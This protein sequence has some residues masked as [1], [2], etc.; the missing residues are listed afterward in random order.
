MNHSAIYDPVRDRMLV[1]GGYDGLG[2]VSGAVWELPLGGAQGWRRVA[3]TGDAPP[4]LSYHAAIYDPDG[5]RMIVYGG[6]DGVYA[7]HDVWALTLSGTPSWTRITPQGTAPLDRYATCAVYDPLRHRVIVFGGIHAAFGEPYSTLNDV[8]ALTLGSDPQWTQLL[9][10]GV[11]PVAR[12]YH[13]KGG[14]YDPAH[15]RMIFFGGNPFSGI[16]LNDVWALDLS[17]PPKWTELLPQGD[18]PPPRTLHSA[19]YDATRARMLVFGGENGSGDLNDTWALTL[20]DPPTWS[21][22]VPL[23][24]L[25]APRAGQASTYDPIRDQ[26]VV[27]GKSQAGDVDL[28]SLSLSGTPEWNTPMP[29]DNLPRRSSAIAIFDPVRARM[30]VF[31]GQLQSSAGSDL[32]TLP[33]AAPEGWSALAASGP[34]PSPRAAGAGTYDPLRDRVVLFGGSSSTPDDT[35]WSLELSPA[36]LWSELPAS[37]T[38]PSARSGHSLVYDSTRDRLLLFGG[39]SAS[40]Q[41]LNDLWSLA[42]QSAPAVWAP[43]AP[44]GAAPGPF[45]SHT[46][47]YD[48]KRDRM[49]MFGRAG[50]AVEVWE[51][52][53]SPG[54]AWHPL[55]G[56]GIGPSAR[57]QFTTIYDVPRD[58]VLLFGGVTSSGFPNPSP[59][60]FK[61]VWAFDLAA[62]TW[63]QVDVAGEE[64]P[65]LWAHTAIYDVPRDRMVVSGGRTGSFGDPT[66]VTWSLQLQGVLTAPG[67]RPALSLLGA[68]PNPAMGRL[69]VSFTLATSAPARLE[70]IDLAGRRVLSRE[71]GSLGAGSH[72][73][74]IAAGVGAA[75]GIYVVRLTQGA[76][77]VST[78][79]V[80]IQ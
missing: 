49:L 78:K 9:P 33:L 21:P 69:R 47:M 56:P 20:G 76:L 1:F 17:G 13:T 35:V 14:I 40:N 16:A 30:L 39:V 28:W 74:P 64:P 54:P 61:D 80:L 34:P 48:G 22:I 65:G 66:S 10:S 25:P 8:W 53:L 50:D 46:A 31:G 27:W 18:P 4:P 79:A 32:W 52:S 60:P 63:S 19:V 24:P 23:G 26:M 51:L 77:V 75:P 70:L 38:A 42:L 73:V 41:A 11:P 67:P 15:D 55:A 72:V 62:G 44:T 37:G 59:I 57:D 2:P 29:T 36:P 43:L 71:V 45:S 5:D 7:A 6:A 3:T 68:W 58:R 12:Y